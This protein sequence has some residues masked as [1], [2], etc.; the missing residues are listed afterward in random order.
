VEFVRCLNKS[1]VPNYFAFLLTRE[2][3]KSNGALKL[4]TVKMRWAP[5]EELKPEDNS[6]D[7]DDQEETKAAGIKAQ[8]KEDRSSQGFQSK[9]KLKFDFVTSLGPKI[10]NFWGEKQKPTYLNVIE[11]AGGVDDQDNDDEDD[12]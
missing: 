8:A 2:R 10:E 9:W 6:F 12:V 11:D 3:V 7:Q 5:N 1:G 4:I